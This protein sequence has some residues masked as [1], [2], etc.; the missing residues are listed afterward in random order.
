MLGY[1]NEWGMWKKLP[2]KGAMKKEIS[3]RGNKSL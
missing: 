1:V 2:K 3:V